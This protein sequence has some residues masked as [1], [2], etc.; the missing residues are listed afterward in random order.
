MALPYFDQ[1]NIEIDHKKYKGIKVT[2]RVLDFIRNWYEEIH[3]ELQV[4]EGFFRH[5]ISHF[6]RFMKSLSS[7]YQISPNNWLVELHYQ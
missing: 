4:K 7:L 5:R 1:N 2:K 6:K 3:I